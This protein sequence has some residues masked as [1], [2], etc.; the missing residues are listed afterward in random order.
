MD[1]TKYCQDCGQELRT[2]AGFCDRCGAEQ[3]SQDTSTTAAAPPE[4]TAQTTDKATEGYGLSRRGL[5]VAGG[6]G[7]VLLGGGLLVARN[8]A[9]A[10]IEQ[11]SDPWSNERREETARAARVRIDVSLS[12]GKYAVWNLNPDAAV[13]YE[14]ELTVESGN[15]AEVFVFD[16]AEFDRFREQEPISHILSFH[17]TGTSLSGGGTLSGGDY[18]LIVDNTAYG[19]A[20][21]EGNVAGELELLA[22]I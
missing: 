15:P 21:P 4:N 11:A 17:D 12:T 13:D 22:G 3:S 5:L 8:Q 7:A 14:Y 1:G 18:R 9:G 6:A 10:G 19:D 20:S 2:D 16:R